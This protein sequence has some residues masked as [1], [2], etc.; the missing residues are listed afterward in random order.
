MLK[1][2]LGYYLKNR[3]EYAILLTL[4]LLNLIYNYV[5]IT[6]D[7]NP[8]SW[9]PS[10]HLML[11]LSYYN[12]LVNP[13]W[14]MIGKLIQVSSYYPPFY[15]FFTAII[16]LFFGTSLTVAMMTNSIFLG[17]LVF[18]V[19]GIG[20]KIFNK[21]TGFIA[22]ILIFLYPSV[23]SFQKMYMLELPLIAMTALSIYFL[24]LTDHFKNLKYSLAF[25]V[26]AALATLTKWTAVLFILGPL[27][28]VVHDTFSPITL[29]QRIKTVISNFQKR[30][31]NDTCQ[32]CG[33][34]LQSDYL[35]Y[36]NKKFCSK[37]C[38][39]KW[40]V[41]NKGR[42]GTASDFPGIRNLF[43][44]V[45]VSI[46]LASIWYVPHLSDVYNNVILGQTVAG[47]AE[48]DPSILTIPSISYYILSIV[49][50]PVSPLLSILF[51]IGLVEVFYLARSNNNN[52]NNNN[53]NQILLL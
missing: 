16:Y 18:S 43:I 52:N 45:F 42:E 37:N 34:T 7:K 13:G 26:A 50:F 33:K 44:A 6:N 31:I 3:Y 2:K 15:H 11:S 32:Y 4:Y 38:K 39:K 46:F 12:I 22:A 35:Q 30:K 49:N 5:W 40:K 48:G 19:F 53:N 17:I 20:K 41:E 25:G 47:A 1:E 14:D 28:C 9:D 27:L 21:E 51:F 8:P 10:A 24:L 29:E 36:E 23:F